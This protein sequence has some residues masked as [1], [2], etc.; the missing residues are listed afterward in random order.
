MLRFNTLQSTLPPED[1]EEI[2]DHGLNFDPGIGFVGFKDKLLDGFLG[3]FLH[4]IKDPG[5]E[6][7]DLG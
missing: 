2:L 3:R 5:P 6:G 1:G 4:K 7:Q